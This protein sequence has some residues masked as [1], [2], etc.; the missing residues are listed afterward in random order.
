MSAEIVNLNR[1]RKARAR[2]DR[3]RAA[4][5]NRAKFGV[6]KSERTKFEAE[7]SKADTELDGAKR[8]TPT[9]AAENDRDGAFDDGSGP[10]QAS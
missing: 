1:V 4:Q 5:E 7:R 10:D 2:A 3:G 8:Q 6:A 9:N